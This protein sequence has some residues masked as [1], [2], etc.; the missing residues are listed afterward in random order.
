[1]GGSYLGGNFWAKPDGSGHSQI[2]PDANNDGFADS[3]FT[4][5]NVTD[6]LPLID[7]PD[8]VVPTAD[9]STSVTSGY[10]PLTVQFTDLSENAVSRSW[11]I[12]DDGIVDSTNKSF[13]H[14]E[15]DTLDSNQTFLLCLPPVNR[16]VKYVSVLR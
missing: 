12:D 15:T 11:D 2:T 5:D 16:V 3:P 8:P 9:F 4:T 6:N 10:A 1:M 7:V 14:E 13:V